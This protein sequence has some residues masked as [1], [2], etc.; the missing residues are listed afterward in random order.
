MKKILFCL[1]LLV[2]SFELVSCSETKDEKEYSYAGVSVD[3]NDFKN[4]Q[5]YEEEARNLY[6]TI[7]TFNPAKDGIEVINDIVENGNK[8]KTIINK[9]LA[10]KEKKENVQNALLYGNVSIIGI[11]KNAIKYSREITDTE[12]VLIKQN[13]KSLNDIEASKITI[14][15]KS[16]DK[17][18]NE[19]NDNIGIEVN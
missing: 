18:I 2:V 1:I 6:T 7:T 9:D 4:I 15:K 17:I 16:S 3:K 12:M 13:F 8:L 14:D 19:L 10:Q 11:P 5:E